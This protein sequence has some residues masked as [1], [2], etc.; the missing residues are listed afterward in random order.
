MVPLP[1]NNMSYIL[2]KYEPLSKIDIPRKVGE[3]NRI[4]SKGTVDIFKGKNLD[5][6]VQLT[7]KGFNM[8]YY[9]F[10]IAYPS[11]SVNYPIFLYQVISA[12]KRVLVVVN[13]ISYK[14]DAIENINGFDNL[15]SLDSEYADM[16][17]KTFE[18]QAFIVENLIPNAFNGL[19]R[20]TEIDKAY[21]RIFSL[22]KNWYEGMEMN[23]NLKHEDEHQYNQWLSN[24]K[25]KFYKEDYGFTATKKFLGEK[26]AK[27]VFENY[28]FN[29]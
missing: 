29:I 12:P 26:W 1:L 23:N 16:L 20:T 10:G 25:N 21:D 17:I 15:L 24:F 14:K 5:K 18:P 11:K 4:I 28:I 19:V 8:Y 27:E 6:F 7:V 3:K 2:S 22:F 9:D 13:Y